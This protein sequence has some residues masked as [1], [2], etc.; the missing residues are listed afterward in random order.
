MVKLLG[1]LPTETVCN[2]AFGDG[3]VR[4]I[5]AKKIDRMTLNALITRAGGEVFGEIP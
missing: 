5:T 3:S 1:T 2:V 4:A